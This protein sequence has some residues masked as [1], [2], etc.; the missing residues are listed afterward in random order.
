MADFMSNIQRGLVIFWSLAYK[1]VFKKFVLQV[2]RRIEDII[3]LQQ[4]LTKCLG[5]SKSL[6]YKPPRCHFYVD[7]KPPL[8]EKHKKSTASKRCVM[9]FWIYLGEEN[10]S[11]VCTVEWFDTV[12]PFKV[13]IHFQ[14]PSH[15]LYTLWG[16]MYV[17][18]SVSKR[19]STLSDT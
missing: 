16:C 17:C 2:L 15:T 18:M 7:V 9:M 11:S 8:Q 13:H 10:I 6:D 14:S 19:C 4:L 1:F 3:S 12:S 5:Y